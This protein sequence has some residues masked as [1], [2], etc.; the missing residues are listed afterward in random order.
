MTITSA[1]IH[2]AAE[3][4]VKRYGD[5]AAEFLQERVAVLSAPEDSWSKNVLLRTLTAVEDLLAHRVV[6]S[7]IRPP[8]DGQGTGQPNSH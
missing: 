3:E 8:Y 6:N 2:R 5:N 4:L 7:A 1:E